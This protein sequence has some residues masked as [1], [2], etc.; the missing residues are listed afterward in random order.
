M[1][2]HERQMQTTQTEEVRRLKAKLKR[3]T[4]DRDMTHPKLG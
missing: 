4:E 1:P 3:V 2:A